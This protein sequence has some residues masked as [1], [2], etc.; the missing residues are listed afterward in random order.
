MI[1]EKRAESLEYNF[2]E[3]YLDVFYRGEVFKQPVKIHNATQYMKDL[4]IEMK[5]QIKEDLMQY[6]IDL[7]EQ[8]LDMKLSSK[9]FKAL[10]EK[11]N[12][13]RDGHIVKNPIDE[14]QELGYT[15]IKKRINGYDYKIITK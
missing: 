4:G 11:L 7:L 3:M 12:F 15:I 10:A 14:I 9:E 6:R 8:H 5:E 13:K 1:N 2:K